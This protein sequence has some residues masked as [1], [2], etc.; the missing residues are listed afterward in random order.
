MSIVVCGGYKPQLEKIENY[1]LPVALDISRGRL[2][3]GLVNEASNHFHGGLKGG[4][5]SS[6]SGE[7]LF[8]RVKNV[9]IHVLR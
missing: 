6:E 1:R 4:K 8:K 5:D 2:G 3:R 9:R 7:V